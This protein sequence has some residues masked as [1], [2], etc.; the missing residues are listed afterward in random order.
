ME[1]YQLNILGV[2]H[3][4]IYRFFTVLYQLTYWVNC[5]VLLG[6]VAERTW[7]KFVL[8]AWTMEFIHYKLYGNNVVTPWKQTALYRVFKKMYH[9]TRGKLF[10]LSLLPGK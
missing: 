6:N 10:L 7:Y 1:A 5:S 8:T 9:E 2:N 3:V 4:G